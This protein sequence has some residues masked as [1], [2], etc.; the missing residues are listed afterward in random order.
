MTWVNE[1]P[2]SLVRK[3]QLSVIG[4]LLI[5]ACA[6]RGIGTEGKGEYQN[7]GKEGKF[8]WENAKRYAF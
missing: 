5:D 3:V 6:F 2:R 7:L 4:N 1:N 8:N